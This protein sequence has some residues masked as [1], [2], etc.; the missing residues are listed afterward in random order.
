MEARIALARASI[1]AAS[2]SRCRTSK[3]AEKP[4]DGF[5]IVL[6]VQDKFLTTPN[7]VQQDGVPS[8]FPAMQAA[9]V[10]ES[11]CIFTGVKP[12]WQLPNA[13]RFMTY[14]RRRYHSGDKIG[15][16]K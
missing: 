10:T 16:Q 9:M 7:S 6:A 15:Y 11:R 3:E 12:F 13:S 4:L 8:H 2:C 5:W 14:K 1:P